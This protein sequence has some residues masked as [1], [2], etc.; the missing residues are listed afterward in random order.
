MTDWNSPEV[1]AS[2][3]ASFS[4]LLHALFGLYIWECVMFLAVDWR[5]VRH[6]KRE[7]PQLMIG[8]LNRYCLLVGLICSMVDPN[9]PSE[10][11]CRPL[12][13]ATNASEPPSLVGEH[14][15]YATD[16]GGM[17]S[18]FLASFVNTVLIWLDLSPVMAVVTVMPSTVVISVRSSS[19]LDS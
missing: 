1:I 17:G 13:L 7:Q 19:P 14:R 11:N 16:S 18:S 4:R 6:I 2:T 8:L 15:A 3:G 12:T 9:I 10:A 5:H